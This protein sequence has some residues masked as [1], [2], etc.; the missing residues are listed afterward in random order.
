MTK[1]TE[2]IVTTRVA[3]VS[4]NANSFGYHGVMLVAEDGTCYEAH[5]NYGRG[6][7]RPAR[8]DIAHLR[9]NPG[10]A[11]TLCRYHDW[12]FDMVHTMH[13]MSANE[14]TK[15]WAGWSEPPAPTVSIELTRSDASQL[16]IGLQA[17]VA[18]LQEERDD[19]EQDENEREVADLDDLIAHYGRIAHAVE[20]Q[21]DAGSK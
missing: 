1:T 15:R 18:T 11:V 4:N 19:A 21:L 14:E 2:N 10:G 8:G 17:R 7:P 5:W 16:V 3:C 6:E 13:S 20:E 9:V 12:S